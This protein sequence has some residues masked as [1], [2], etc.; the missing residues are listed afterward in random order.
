M[1]PM[2]ADN[3]IKFHPLQRSLTPTVPDFLHAHVGFAPNFKLF[4]HVFGH[5]PS[6]HLPPRVFVV[7]VAVQILMEQ[8][9]QLLADGTGS[10]DAVGAFEVGTAG[11]TC[12]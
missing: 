12:M 11:S 9:V 5:H 1:V 7:V 3:H 8:G 2:V 6:H 10:R 4:Q